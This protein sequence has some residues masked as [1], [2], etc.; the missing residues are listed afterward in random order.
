MQ[1]KEQRGGT[2]EGRKREKE[3]RKKGKVNSRRLLL[4][5]DEQTESE[6]S[7]GGQKDKGERGN[8]FKCLCGFVTAFRNQRILKHLVH[9]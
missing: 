8:C 4:T 1:L 2:A 6:R 5:T 9:E 3:G 7:E